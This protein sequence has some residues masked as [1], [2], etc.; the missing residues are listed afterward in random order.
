MRSRPLALELLDHRQQVLEVLAAADVGDDRRA[1]DAAALVAEQLAEPG[2][3]PRRQVVD[4]EV[5]AVLEG[6]DR[7]GLAGPRV[8]GD[9]DHLDP[10]RR[11]AVAAGRTGS[12]GSRPLAPRGA[13][14]A[15]SRLPWASIRPC[16][17]A[18]GSRERAYRAPRAPLRAPR[19]WRTSS[20]SGEPKWRSRARFRAGPTPRTPSSTEAV[21]AWSRRLRWKVIA[22]RCASSR[23]RCSSRSASEPPLEPDRALAPRDEDLLDPLR[24]A[25][26]GDAALGQRLERL[27]IPAESWPLP[28]SITT[29]SGSAA[30]LASRSASWGERSACSR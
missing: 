11:G 14:P 3:H 23:T 25:D 4:A 15:S 8:A 20:R 12:A 29:R 26:H 17:V 16:S 13:C 27:R 22:K 19:G 9:H 7:L 6:G 2:D 1:L 21:I 28:P 18:G 30:K 5:A 24:E 10:L